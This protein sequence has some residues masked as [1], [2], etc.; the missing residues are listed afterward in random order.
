MK[1]LLILIVGLLL[2]SSRCKKSDDSA[3]GAITYGNKFICTINGKQFIPQKTGVLNGVVVFEAG[4]NRNNTMYEFNVQAYD[5]NNGPTIGIL[6][7]SKFTE[8]KAGVKLPLGRS[9]VTNAWATYAFSTI[10]SPGIIRYASIISPLTGELVISNYDATT[11]V[12]TG[13]FW[14]DA[15]DEAGNKYEVRDGKFAI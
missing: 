13:T 15:V 14:F 11:R 3:P 4:Y 10:A 6:L 7:Q 5:V 9:G 1:N 8:L 2:M 12:L